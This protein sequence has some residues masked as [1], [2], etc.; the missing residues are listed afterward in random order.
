MAKTGK[1]TENGSD[2]KT[3][4]IK[5]RTWMSENLRVTKFLN[6]DAIP[7]AKTDKEWKDAHKK[8]KPAF[9]YFKNDSAKDVL[10]NWWAIEDSRGLAPEGW[11]I[12]DETD[13]Y[14][15]LQDLGGDE[16]AFESLKSKEGW[17][18][19]AAGNGKSKFEAKPTGCRDKDGIFAGD[20]IAYFWSRSEGEL[21]L[22]S[23][24]YSFDPPYRYSLDEENG[25]AVRCVKPLIFD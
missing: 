12:P 18:A 8:K 13:F 7:E 17:A 4:K 3:I 14:E 22:S 15:L 9:C 10:Y 21:V 19:E 24:Y 2:Y 25:L 11:I 16:K 6:G 1:S 5:K 20:G 23:T